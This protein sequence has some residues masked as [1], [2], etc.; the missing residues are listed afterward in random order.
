[1]YTKRQQTNNHNFSQLSL[2]AKYNAAQAHSISFGSTFNNLVSNGDISAILYISVK[3]LIL[4]RKKN[5]LSQS[6]I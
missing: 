5:L 1:M 6:S 3:L 2:H 4:R